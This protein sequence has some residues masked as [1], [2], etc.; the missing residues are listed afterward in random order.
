ME[1][2]VRTKASRRSSQEDQW[3]VR[4]FVWLEYKIGIRELGQ[5]W[6]ECW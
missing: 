6:K 1:R 5:S 2:R 3:S 4:S